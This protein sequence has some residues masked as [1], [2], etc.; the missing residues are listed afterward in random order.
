MYSREDR[1]ASLWDIRIK[2]CLRK[3]NEFQTGTKLPKDV[4]THAFDPT[5]KFYCLGGIRY[6][7]IYS[8][9][10]CFRAD[11]TSI[12]KLM[13]PAFRPGCPY[14]RGHLSKRTSRISI[15]EN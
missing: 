2:T 14:G 9:E 10:V 13:F 6:M 5:G 3:F 11:A 12:W 15:G 4:F 7:V 1:E 8:V